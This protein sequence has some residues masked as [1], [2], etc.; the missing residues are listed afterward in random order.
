M[1]KSAS[2][3]FNLGS[4]NIDHV[5]Q[6]NHMVKPGETLASLNYFKAAG[7]KGFNQSLALARAGARVQ[8]LGA[9]GAEGA[10]LWEALEREGIFIHSKLLVEEPTGHAIIQV[11]PE[12][13]NSILLFAGANQKVGKLHLQAFLSQ[14]RKGDWFLTQNETSSVKDAIDL[15][16]EK[17]LIV[18]FNPAPMDDSVKSLP[19][20]KIHW[21]ILNETE[22]SSLSGV[23]EP[24]EILKILSFRYPRTNLILTLG[25]SGVIA[26]TVD[27]KKHKVP[28]VPVVAVD[29]TAAGDTLIGFL[30]SS[31]MLGK[32][33]EEA[34][35]F[36]VKA[37]SICV[38]RAG[39]GKSIPRVEELN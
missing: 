14:A 11:S 2:T 35:N 12:G 20:E 29:T 21:L 19:L 36:A 37:A 5:Y 17:G 16:Y 3:I 7:G 6:V 26:Q 38:T 30:L 31:L 25:G 22:G 10:F 34:L 15:A 28:A 13:E 27:L 24:E 4:L 9:T 32:E 33:L 23:D 8:H 39:A 18:C 1:L